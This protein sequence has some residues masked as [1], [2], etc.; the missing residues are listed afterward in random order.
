MRRGLVELLQH[1]G[2]PWRLTT[3]HL[4]TA[5][6][7]LGLHPLLAEC[8]P[9][10]LSLPP[11]YHRREEDG[12]REVDGE[13]RSIMVEDTLALVATL[14]TLP[15]R[16]A[17]AAAPDRLAL[18]RLLCALALAPSLLPRPLLHRSTSLILHSLLDSC[19]TNLLDSTLQVKSTSTTPPPPP[20]HPST[21]TS[22][23]LLSRILLRIF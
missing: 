3:T 14:L 17:L 20:L 13:V 4:L 12:R 8:W 6:R 22:P 10:P 2:L 23:L 5:L 9:E 15:G 7:T 16:H 11:F 19:P 21:S 1:S 18:P